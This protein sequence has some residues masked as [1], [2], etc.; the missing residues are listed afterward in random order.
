MVLHSPFIISSA[1]APGLQ[2]GGA[3][4]SL[5][6]TEEVHRGGFFRACAKFELYTPDFI[7]VD[8]DLGSG[9]GGFHSTVE[10]F[11]TYLSFLEAAA[12]SHRYG[13]E[14]SDLFPKHV[15]AWAA[16]HIDDIAAVRMSI[17]DEDGNPNVSLIEE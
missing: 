7:H 12:E 14:N 8:E 16:D 1:L 11:E 17:C 6:S 4:L 10:I 5:L 3:T 2:I 13:G 9:V 15:V